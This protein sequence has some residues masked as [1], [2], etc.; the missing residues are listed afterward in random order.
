MVEEVDALLPADCSDEHRRLAVRL[1]GELGQVHLFARWPPAGQR[2]ADKTQLL[3][4][5]ATVEANDPGG[6]AAYIALAHPPP[7]ARSPASDDAV[8][9][10]AGSD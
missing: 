8:S 9:G 1:L 2:D 7:V 10:Y 3:A 4:E 6:L 5:L